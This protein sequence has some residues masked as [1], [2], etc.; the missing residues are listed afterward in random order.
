MKSLVIIITLTTAAHAANPAHYMR[1]GVL[2]VRRSK[3]IEDRAADIIKRQCPR[4]TEKHIRAAIDS[5]QTLRG[6]DDDALHLARGAI[7]WARERRSH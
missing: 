6:P 4:C 5:M 7:I 3:V 2:M 1:D